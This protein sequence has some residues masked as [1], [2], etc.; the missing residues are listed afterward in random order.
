PWLDDQLCSLIRLRWPSYLGAVANNW[1]PAMLMK[2]SVETSQQLREMLAERILV[3]DGSMGALIMAQK[4]SE[5]TYRGRRF[6]NHNV[7]LK[8]C[9]DVLTLTQPEMIENI[10]REYL[11]A[12]ADI[13]ETCT[14]NATSFGLSHFNL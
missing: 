6:A 9:T 14:F 4:P 8:N 13:I 11:E 2:A 3:L 7:L 10:H 1:I 12:G 5:E